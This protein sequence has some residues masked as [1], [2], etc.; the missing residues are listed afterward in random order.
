MS[1]NFGIPR[2]HLHIFLFVEGYFDSGTIL[3]SLKV[4]LS[5]MCGLDCSVTNALWLY[6]VKLTA[7]KIKL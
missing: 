6:S 2:L 7:A 1:A 3:L 4:V 5:L